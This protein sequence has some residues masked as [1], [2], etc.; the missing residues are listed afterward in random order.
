M[1]RMRSPCCARADSGQAAAPPSS[2]MNSRRLMGASPPA[3]TSGK[4]R[5]SHSAAV[6]LVHHSKFGTPMT[7]MGQTRSIRRCRLNVRF[8][9]KRAW[10]ERSAQRE[11]L[12]QTQPADVSLA[13]SNGPCGQLSCRSDA[14]KHRSLVSYRELN[15]P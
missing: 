4:L 14:W 6:P 15:D 11:K 1:R 8:A 7:A 5:L 13:C 10:I 2:V 9:R 3:E 12:T